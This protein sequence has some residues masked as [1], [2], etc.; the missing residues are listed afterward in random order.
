MNI[1]KIKDKLI[2]AIKYTTETLGTKLVYDSYGSSLEGCSCALSC[3]LTINHIDYNQDNAED[4]IK[5]LLS[6][7]EDWIVAFTTGFD[8]YKYV[9]K[10]NQFDEK[11]LFLMETNNL[12][13]ELRKLFSPKA[14]R[15]N[16]HVD[17]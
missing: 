3:L 6:V 5:E 1:N 7:E 10:Y 12:G 11:E 9:R 15:V 8:N 14:Y 13:S 4:K 16:D 2:N 17:D